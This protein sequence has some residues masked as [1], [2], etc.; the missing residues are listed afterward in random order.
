MLAA[1]VSTVVSEAGKGDPWMGQN[2]DIRFGLEGTPLAS[3]PIERRGSPVAP[4]SAWPSLL[5]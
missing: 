3:S 5:M 2:P 4:A 1:A